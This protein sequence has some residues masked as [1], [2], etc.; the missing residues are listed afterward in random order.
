MACA[1]VAI[2]TV[3]ALAVAVPASADTGT[4]VHQSG[5]RVTSVPAGVPRKLSQA[6]MAAATAAPA[7]GAV[8]PNLACSVGYVCGKAA[9]GHSFAYYHCNH[10]YTLPDM[11]GVGPYNNNQTGNAAAY[12]YDQDGWLIW[13]SIAPDQG[14]VDWTSIWYA[15]ACLT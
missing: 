4:T 11:V 8:A 2:G 6:Q 10:L 14:T 12:Y 9:N 1:V 7:A 3:G 5:T 15:Y 13:V